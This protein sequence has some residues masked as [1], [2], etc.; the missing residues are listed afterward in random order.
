MRWIKGAVA[1]GLAAGLLMSTTAWAAEKEASNMQ[2]VKGG[3]EIVQGA[4]GKPVDKVGLNESQ[5][6]AME[7]I[8]QIIP[9]PLLAYMPDYGF[10]MGYID[11]LTGKTMML[12]ND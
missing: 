10:S 8:Y 2:K 3:T 6:Q 12:E 11:A 4:A 5:Q 1:A 7:K 9:E